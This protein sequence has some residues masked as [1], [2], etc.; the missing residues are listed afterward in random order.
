MK[1]HLGCGDKRLEGF[2]NV[3]FRE[4]SAV[5]VVDD[6]AT[7]KNIS[8]GS[9]DLIYASHI[10]EH[11]GRNEYKDVLKRWYDVLKP[12]GVLRLAVPDFGAVVEW[13]T[14]TARDL[15]DLR[16]L[17]YGGQDY[18]GN[19]HYCCWDR[20]TLEK[21]LKEAGFVFV[22]SWDWKKTEHSHVDDYSQ[23]YL[24]HMDKE[25]GMLMS[26]NLEATK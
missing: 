20:T 19:F 5:D 21:D 11:F 10:L 22:T 3:D 23:S 25:K 16:G 9:V 1:L 2:V 24:P 18:P 17:L 12:R 8:D 26:L 13:Y 4:T 15:T 6:A 7:L 14:L